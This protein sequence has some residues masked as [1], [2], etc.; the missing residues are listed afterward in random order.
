M[1]EV[2][3]KL[4]LRAER[5]RMCFLG[6]EVIEFKIVFGTLLAWLACSIETY[7]AGTPGLT[8]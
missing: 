7:S 1:R 8:L 3:Q 4:R 6:S 5:S 2:V